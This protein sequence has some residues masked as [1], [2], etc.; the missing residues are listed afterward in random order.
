ME[1]KTVTWPECRPQGARQIY[2]ALAAQGT[3][4]ALP[5]KPWTILSSRILVDRR[6]LRLHEQRVELPNGTVIEEFH[7]IESPDWVAVLA[8]TPENQV[9]LVDQYRHGIA[10]VSRELPAGVIDAGETP[11]VAARR[12]LLEET[13]YVAEEL[14]P[15][16]ALGPEP[17]RS[18]HLGHFFFAGNVRF[19]G[20]ANPEPSEVLEVN[21]RPVA[22]VIADALGGRII[23]AA[24]T[25][26]ILAAH[27]RGLIA[28]T[29]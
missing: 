26:A 8:I 17:H 5:M 11:A 14:L 23:H 9:V 12:E 24:H 3:S 16:F 22:E 10:R 21:L 4:C 27:A 25:A 2:L 1:A 13:G 28:N 19:S 20:K 6:W 7:R 18:S 15:I 29:P